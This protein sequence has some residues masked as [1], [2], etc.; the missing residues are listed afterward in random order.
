MPLR[1]TPIQ[2][3]SRRRFSA[4]PGRTWRLW[5]GRHDGESVPSALMTRE[6]SWQVDGATLTLLRHVTS[7]GY[8]VSVFRFPS[9]ALG[10][11]PACVEMHALDLSQDP[12]IT[13]VARVVEG[14]DG[15]LDYRCAC[16]LAELVGIDLKDADLRLQPDAAHHVELAATEISAAAM[17]ASAVHS[18][19][20]AACARDVPSRR[21]RSEICHVNRTT[22]EQSP[23]V[24]RRRLHEPGRRCRRTSDPPSSCGT[25]AR[26]AAVQ[27]SLNPRRH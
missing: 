15:D 21:C 18:N 3:R 10:S 16:L 1:L 26:Q 7:L 24:H 6:Q 5:R 8:T 19:R 25:V 23:R 20:L 14:E 2:W 9:S 12:P 27:N 17:S 22:E 4:G 13:H 11:W